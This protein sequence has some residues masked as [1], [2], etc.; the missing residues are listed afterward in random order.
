MDF[1]AEILFEVFIYGLCIIPGAFV[2]WLFLFKK[3]SFKE[4]LKQDAYFNGI[5]GFVSVALVVTTVILINQ[6]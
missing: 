3:Y 2:R 4:I 5:I 6:N 1:I